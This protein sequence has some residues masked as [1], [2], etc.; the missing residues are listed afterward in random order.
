MKFSPDTSNRDWSHLLGAAKWLAGALALSWLVAFV[1]LGYPWTMVG[2]SLDALSY[3]WMAD[4]LSHGVSRPESAFGAQYLFLS[5]FPPGYP[6]YLA[7]FGAGVDAD[8]MLRANLAQMISVIALILMLWVYALRL[9]RSALAAWLVLVYTLAQPMMLPWSL[10]LFSEPLYAALLLGICLLSSIERLPR[11]WLWMAVLIGFACLV[12]SIGLA[13]IPALALWLWRT[14]RSPVRALA[15]S[16]IAALP[17][18]VWSL[19]K[20][21]QAAGTKDSYLTQLRSELAN[22]GDQWLD[23]VLAQLSGL[24]SALAPGSLPSALQLAIGG[25]V[26]TLFARGAWRERERPNFTTLAVVFTLLMLVAWPFPRYLDRLAGP[27]VPLMLISIWG[28]WV[29]RTAPTSATPMWSGYS[30]AVVGIGA[31]IAL[32]GMT[33]ALRSFARPALWTA[34]TTLTPYLRNA[35]VFAGSSPLL[36]AK[37]HHASVLS[38]G[39]LADVVPEPQCVSTT[40]AAWLMLHTKVPVR[41]TA[42]PFDWEHNPC[43][44]VFVMNLGSPRDGFNGMYPMPL[45][46][47]QFASVFISRE[48]SEAPVLAAL[49]QRRQP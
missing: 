3:L 26:L 33:G 49:I 46:R 16:V 23:L 38:A 37:I 28:W 40:F 6:I 35:S 48:S 12:R 11:A 4:A 20:P 42:I 14:Q 9:T 17:V 15:A 36:V 8:G 2:S 30:A 1:A 5:R 43:R 31:I 24:V 34:E 21:M 45:P 19:L 10:E 18:A 32:A 41:D 39:R 47:G 25:A 29:P 22:T 13:L 27:I 7:A 44:F